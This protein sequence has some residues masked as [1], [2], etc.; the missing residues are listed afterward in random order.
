MGN[1]LAIPIVFSADPQPKITWMKDGMELEGQ[2]NIKITETVHDI[3][4]GLKEYT[5][6]INFDESK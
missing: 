5:Y 6:T 2:C 1:S 4:N 3:E